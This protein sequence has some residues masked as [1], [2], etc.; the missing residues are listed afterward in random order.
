MLEYKKKMYSQFF[1]KRLGPNGSLFPVGW[2]NNR[3]GGGR[4]HGA[5]SWSHGRAD[6]ASDR[7]N[8][9]S[10]VLRCGAEITTF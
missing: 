2:I 10:G 6:E 4:G 1:D 9:L 3:L 8:T 5:I 7:T